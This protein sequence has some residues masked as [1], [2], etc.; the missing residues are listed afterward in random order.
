M[1]P[2]FIGEAIKPVA[3]TF[4]AVRMARGEPGLPQAFVWRGHTVRIV[5]VRRAW[6]DTGP[7]R[8]GSGEQYIRKHWYEVLTA[9]DGVLTLYF[10][11]QARGR[12][13]TARWWLFSAADAGNTEAD[14]I[15]QP[16]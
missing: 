8:H 12:R 15:L 7:C 16:T 4:D 1:N 14:K 13:K 9:A 10:E 6:T 11:R 2:H 3:T 5:K